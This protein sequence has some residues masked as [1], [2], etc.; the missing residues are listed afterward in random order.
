MSL[1]NVGNNSMNR[2]SIPN[3]LLKTMFKGD[4]LINFCHLN[5]A[6]VKPKLINCELFFIMLMLMPYPSARRGLKVIIQ[7]NR[8]K[9]KG[10]I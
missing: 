1:S 5:V 3:V 9:L 8:L 4:N 10:T 2:V 6:S 7:T